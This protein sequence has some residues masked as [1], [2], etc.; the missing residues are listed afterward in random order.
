MVL[1]WYLI[2]LW[3]GW[4][5]HEC[6]WYDSNHEDQCWEHGGCFFFLHLF[7]SIPFHSIPS[8]SHSIPSTIQCWICALKL[9]SISQQ[10]MNNLLDNVQQISSASQSVEVRLGSRLNFNV[11]LSCMNCWYPFRLLCSVIWILI[12]P[13]LKNWWGSSSYCI[14][15][16]CI[17]ISLIPNC[18]LC[19]WIHFVCWSVDRLVKRLQFLFE[20][21]MRLQQ[22]VDMGAYAQAVKYFTKAEMVLKKYANTPSFEKV[23]CITLFVSS[24]SCPPPHCS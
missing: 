6:Y 19:I 17:F 13:E 7:H 9:H 4:I 12:E 10:E 18:I 8:Q 22:C 5:V 15:P 20:L 3:I 21:P 14:I 1:S 11:I 24:S 16:L 23:S 2:V